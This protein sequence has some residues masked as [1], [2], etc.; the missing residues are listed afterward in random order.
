MSGPAL[1]VADILRAHGEDY[2]RAQENG[3][4]FERRRVLKALTACRTPVLGGQVKRCD[5]C[6]HTAVLFH[7]CRNRHCPKC[8]AAARAEWLDARAGELLSGVPYYHVV[9]TLPEPLAQHALQN[10]RLLYGILFRAASETLQTIA[11]DPAHLGAQIGFVAVLHTWGQTLHHHPHLHGVIPGGGICP[12]G[13]RWI[14][15][16]KGFFL[17]VRV[18][19]ALFK[20]KFLC[21][22]KAARE[23]G[24]LSFHGQLTP[25]EKE[26][27][28]RSF[29]SDLYETGWVVYAKRP[30]GSPEHVLKYLARYT[31]RVA[32]SNQR[33]LALENGQVTFRYKDYAH[34]NRQRTMTLQAV[35]FIRRFLLHTLP[36]NFMRIRHYGFLANRNRRQALAQCRTLLDIGS[37][38]E[39][40]ATPLGGDHAPKLSEQA[41]TEDCP[42]CGQGHMLVIQTVASGQK[43]PL[44]FVDFLQPWDTS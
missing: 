24:K 19:S 18:L 42:A 43:W 12:A 41:T 8:Q 13:D 5:N 33:L 25:L 28:W 15:C 34:N 27:R 35:E 10:K 32:I 6:G 14:S 17:P 9:F 26:T 30:F 22:L 38:T 23:S 7:S 20:K 3:T 16:R 37:N 1:E 40:S 21:Y 4:P 29:V 44:E 31:H 39:D 36:L 2:L 11:R